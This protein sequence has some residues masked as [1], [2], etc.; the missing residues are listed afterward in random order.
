[1]LAILLDYAGKNILIDSGVFQYEDGERR[2][3]ARSTAAHNTVVID[4]LDQ[5]ELWKSFRM[6]RRGRPL[7]LTLN[8]HTLR[9][10]HTGFAIW[11]RSLNHERT[12][13]LF[14]GGFNILDELRGPGHH[15]YEAFF[16]FAPDVFIEEIEEGKY[17]I[18]KLLFLELNGAKSLL[19]TSEYYPEFGRSIIRP[20]LILSGTFQGQTQLKIRFS[21]I[22]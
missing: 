4:N 19:T 16:H 12:L 2:Q 22:S 3:Y 15:G 20:C 14:D 11:R 21:S 1:M 6:G 9:C 5:A 8:R 18:N 17:R 10:S 7:N 13:S